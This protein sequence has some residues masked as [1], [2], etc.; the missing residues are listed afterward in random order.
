MAEKSIHRLICQGDGHQ[1]LNPL[2]QNFRL[3]NWIDRFGPTEK[4]AKTVPPFEVDHFSR[5]DLSDQKRKVSMISTPSLRRT[6]TASNKLNTLKQLRGD[7]MY[8]TR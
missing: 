5:L 6:Q 3:K 1:G 4:V 7:Y 8:N 2:D